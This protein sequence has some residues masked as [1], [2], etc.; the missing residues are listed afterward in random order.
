MASSIRHL[1]LLRFVSLAL[2]ISAIACGGAAATGSPGR[3]MPT[4]GLDRGSRNDPDALG[5]IALLADQPTPSELADIV[6]S[7]SS[8]VVNITTVVPTASTGPS[9]LDLLFR[10]RR[11]PMRP[12]ER[13]GAGTGFVIDREGYVVTNAHV[14][15]GAETVLIKLYDDRQLA[16]RVIGHDRKLDLAL[17]KMDGA[18]DLRPVALGDS[19]VLRVG[20]TVIAVGNP[21][22][23]GHT[24]TTGIVSAKARSIGAG[25]YDDFIQ[26]DASINPGNSGGPLFNR[27]GEVVGINTAIRAGA[28]GIGFAIPVNALKDVL[29]QLRDKG[30]VERGKLG[31]EYQPVS[32]DIARALRLDRPQGAMV[33]DVLAGSPAAG[34]GLQSGDV[35][36]AVEDRPIRRAEDL[37][38]NVARHAP[39]AKIRIRYLR[40]GEVAETVAEL[41]RLEGSE[42]PPPGRDPVR[43]DEDASQPATLMGLRL[44]DEP[45]GAGV[46]VKAMK[47]PYKGLFVGDLI[48]AVNGTAVSNRAALEQ[49]VEGLKVGDVAL[50]KVRRNDPR[51]GQHH[52]YVGVP[53]A[54]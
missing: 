38:R 35:I 5:R 44:V 1:R 45:G 16:A 36:V 3:G 43:D 54:E 53:L 17:L 19:S 7:L 10:G 14:V 23:L 32:G 52:R 41:A 34:A 25:P 37:P 26:T 48:V 21:F 24:V 2:A 29:T 18:G 15:D 4:Y 49:V 13:K 28:D 12:R 50:F 8:S 11:G 30:F 31:I 47:R 6:E 20:E 22:G 27:R 33:A 42:G 46:R 51:G 39:G 40:D 9:P